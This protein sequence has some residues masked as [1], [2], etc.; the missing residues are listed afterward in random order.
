MHVTSPS[1]TILVA[2][3]GLMSLTLAALGGCRSPP[4]TRPEL[5][6]KLQHCRAEI[7]KSAGNGW[8]ESPCT[9]LDVS[10]LNGI[11]RLELVTAL[12]QPSYCVGLAEAQDPRGPDCPPTLEPKW[13]FF[14]GAGAGPQ[15][16]CET[17]QK[18][19]CELVRWLRSDSRD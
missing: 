8:F 5:L 2:A 9:K 19:S 6:D 15:L 7:T 18:Q 3:A 4:P 16:I 13:D 10:H 12:G 14:R 1:R 11:T 17:D